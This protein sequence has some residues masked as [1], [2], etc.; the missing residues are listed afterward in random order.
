MLFFTCFMRKY[1]FGKTR[2]FWLKDVNHVL[3]WSGFLSKIHEQRRNKHYISFLYVILTYILGNCKK[4][5]L[6][7]QLQNEMIIYHDISDACKHNISHTCCRICQYHRED[8]W[9]NAAQTANTELNLQLENW[10]L[11]NLIATLI[12]GI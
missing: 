9:T 2:V 1:Y 3:C 7:R 4:C 8:S 6:E 11:S 10:A 5:L 12:T